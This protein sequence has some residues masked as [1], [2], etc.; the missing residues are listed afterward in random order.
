MYTKL[1]VGP[2]KNKLFEVIN[3]V[4]KGA[5][6]VKNRAPPEHYFSVTGK[7]GFPRSSQKLK[8]H[9]IDDAKLWKQKRT[10]VR[11]RMCGAVREKVLILPL[12]T[13]ASLSLANFA[14]GPNSEKVFGRRSF[15]IDSET[16]L[17]TAEYARVTALRR[18]SKS[19]AS[20]EPPFKAR[21]TPAKTSACIKTAAFQSCLEASKSWCL[22]EK[23]SKV[24]APTRAS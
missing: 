19:S 6:R 23:V 8:Y 1:Q 18:A 4:P 2:G 21:E 9:R 13:E 24:R 17:R 12:L 5:G 3:V 7:G 15:R 20:P 14:E 11:A 16:S 10:P 22:V